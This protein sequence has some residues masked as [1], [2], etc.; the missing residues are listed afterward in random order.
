MSCQ[1][2]VLVSQISKVPYGI[3]IEGILSH[4]NGVFFVLNYSLGLAL[5]V[6]WWE[7]F[8]LGLEL[9]FWSAN[10]ELFIFVSC[11]GMMLH[12]VV[13][14]KVSFAVVLRLIE[15]TIGT[16]FGINNCCWLES[17]GQNDVWIHR[18]N[19]YVIDQWIKDILFAVNFLYDFHELILNLVLNL[20]QILCLI[21][22]CS[23]FNFQIKF[24]DFLCVLYDLLIA[25]FV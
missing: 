25:L 1:G 11:E 18:G 8:Q 2:L 6:F 3:H 14:A 19:V 7:L 21:N 17:V 4:A 15:N 9:F 23:F 12:L 10:F 22:A 13:P 16:R 24:Y 20:N 5:V